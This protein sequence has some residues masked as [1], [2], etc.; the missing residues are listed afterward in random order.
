MQEITYDAKKVRGL[1]GADDARHSESEEFP[2][3]V[4]LV[5]AEGEAAWDPTSTRSTYRGVSG[6]CTA[7][8]LLHRDGG[9]DLRLFP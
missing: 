6:P 8:Y 2:R 1:L 7:R 9:I 4:L 3:E 5:L